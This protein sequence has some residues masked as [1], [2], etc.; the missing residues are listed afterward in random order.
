MR[1]TRPALAS[2]VSSSCKRTFCRSLVVARARRSSK[3]RERHEPSEQPAGVVTL[4]SGK[5][6]R[7]AA[8]QRLHEYTHARTSGRTDDVRTTVPRTETSCPTRSA[9]MSPSPTSGVTRVSRTRV[10]R[11]SSRSRAAAGARGRAA[12]AARRGRAVAQARARVAVVG[13]VAR[14]SV[15]AH[16]SC[17]S[18]LIGLRAQRRVEVAHDRADR[19][20]EARVVD[21]DLARALVDARRGT[22]RRPR[23]PIPRTTL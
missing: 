12:D 23:R 15:A 9:R 17:A 1:G 19:R 14:A 16:A 10:S 5:A 22:A 11:R 7:T 2:A 20:A 21:L 13:R 4:P 6:Q 8:P 18:T 3:S